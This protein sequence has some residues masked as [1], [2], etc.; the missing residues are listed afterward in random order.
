MVTSAN[1]GPHAN[2]IRDRARRGKDETSTGSA[3]TEWQR[4]Q[5]SRRPQGLPDLPAVPLKTRMQLDEAGWQ[6][7]RRSRRP[8]GLPAL[9]PGHSITGSRGCPKKSWRKTQLTR[10]ST[11]SCPPDLRKPPSSL[12]R[13]GGGPL[14]GRKLCLPQ[15]LTTPDA[16]SRMEAATSCPES[17]WES[18]HIPTGYWVYYQSVE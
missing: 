9:R 14:C 2:P 17:F 13:H 7:P 16:P 15:R 8:Q 3:D 6:A 1:R 12:R 5:R 18:C 10:K 11:P 4:P